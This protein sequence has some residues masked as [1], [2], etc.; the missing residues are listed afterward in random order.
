MDCVHLLCPEQTLCDCTFGI[1]FLK[2]ATVNGLAGD[3][4][5]L[6]SVSLRCTAIHFSAVLILAVLFV[7]VCVLFKC[8]W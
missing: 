5:G 3:S 6:L 2:C 8:E 7:C 4:S 1:L